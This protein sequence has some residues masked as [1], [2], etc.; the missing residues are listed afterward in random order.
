MIRQRLRRALDAL[1]CYAALSLAT[2]K[3]G[4]LTLEV[5][6]L[7]IALETEREHARRLRDLVEL[8][9]RERDAAEAR[10]RS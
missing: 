2:Y 9:T 5:T 8:R 4:L 1:G 7:R 6:G 3:L 10:L